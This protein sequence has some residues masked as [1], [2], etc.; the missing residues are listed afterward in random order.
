RALLLAALAR[1]AATEEFRDITASRIREV[2]GLARRRFSVHFDSVEDCFLTA[3]EARLRAALARAERAEVQSGVWPGGVSRAIGTICAEAAA[4][5]VFAG[6]CFGRASEAVE[7]GAVGADRRRR[8]LAEVATH[9]RSGVPAATRPGAFEVEASLEAAWA[10]LRRHVAD[11]RPGRPPEG[12]ASVAYLVLA[13]LV[14]PE[15]AVAAIRDDLAPGTAA[16][17]GDRVPL[18]TAA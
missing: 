16:N 1:L 3:L 5:P 17:A 13:P 2:A 9:V 10:L 7:G 4:D 6:L 15:A 8:F 14:G 12:V 11:G 18:E